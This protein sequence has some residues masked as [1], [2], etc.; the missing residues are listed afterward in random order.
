MRKSELTQGE[1]VKAVVESAKAIYD[2]SRR[3]GRKRGRQKLEPTAV[4]WNV[5]NQLLAVIG[6]VFPE[7]RPTIEQYI[8]SWYQ[9]WNFPPG[10]PRLDSPFGSDPAKHIAWDRYM[11]AISVVNED[12][13]PE[14]WAIVDELK[15][16]YESLLTQQD[17]DNIARARQE[18]NQRMGIP[19]FE[20]S[21]EN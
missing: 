9:T 7:T 1:F 8:E 17:R 11:M 5:R 16:A 18:H 13:T 2:E 14:N 6:H 10:D 19:E 3:I 20:L 4:R 15:Q 12:P 21:K